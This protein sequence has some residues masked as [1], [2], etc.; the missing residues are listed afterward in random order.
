MKIQRVAV[1][2]AGM[3]GAACARQL[4]DAGLDVTVFDKSRGLG[5]R[6]ATRRAVLPRDASADQ[7]LTFDH[8]APWWVSS[9]RDFAEF[10]KTAEAQ[11]AVL[12]W[13]PRMKGQSAHERAPS[14]SQSWVAQPD[15]PGLVRWMLQGI[16]VHTGC[17]IGGLHRQESGWELTGDGMPAASGFDAV[18]VAIPPA[19]AAALWAPHTADWTARAQAQHMSPCWTLMG[20]TDDPFKNPAAGATWDVLTPASGPLSLVV[21]QDGKPG[22]PA[23]AGQAHWVA[24]ATV[25]WTEQHL[26]SAPDGALVA[27][28]AALESALGGALTWRHAVV[29]RWRYAQWSGAAPQSMPCWWDGSAGLGACGDY[30]GGGGVEGAW[31][32]G[33]NLARAILG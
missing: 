30:L 15:M 10:L 8:G 9:T 28:K 25:D 11:G 32:S 14:E 21:R 7:T 2:G 20:V 24:H 27:L 19:Q 5:G 22:R 33:G 17:T 23:H 6:M 3:A 1:I 18:A 16:A 4:A 13:T 31:L 12:Q 29:H 26:E